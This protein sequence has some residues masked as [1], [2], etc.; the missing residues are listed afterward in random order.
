MGLKDLMS[1]KS[2]QSMMRFA[3]FFTLIIAGVL[4]LVL[5]AVLIIRAYQDHAIDW[6][7][8]AVFLGAIA[9]TITGVTG[10]KA[11]QKGKEKKE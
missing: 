4:G 2:E 10:M 5:G 9:A 11:L 8:C 6:S 3:V 7:G 1:E